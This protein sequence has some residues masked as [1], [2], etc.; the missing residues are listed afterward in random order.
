MSLT[1]ATYAMITG[2]QANVLDFGAD[3]TGVADSTTAIQAAYD[4]LPAAITATAPIGGGTVYFPPGQYKTTA[5]ISI[6]DDNIITKGNGAT[7]QPTHT[8]DVFVIGPDGETRQF[9]VFD[10]IIVKPVATTRDIVRFES[11][12]MQ[13][14]VLNCRFEGA[15]STYTTGY[16]VNFASTIVAF[17]NNNAIT[18]SYFRWL[19]NGIKDGL[20]QVELLIDNCRF[21]NL[22]NQ[23]IVISTG[24]LTNVIACNFES[25]GQTALTDTAIVQFGKTGGP[26]IGRCSIYGCHFEENGST[27]SNRNFDLYIQE[28]RSVLVTANRFYA[29]PTYPTKTAIQCE[30]SDNITVLNNEYQDYVSGAVDIGST[31]ADVVYLGNISVSQPEFTGTGT[32]GL[33]KFAQADGNF[34]VT[35]GSTTTANAMAIKDSAGA[36]VFLAFADGSIG[37]DALANGSSTATF[38]STTKPGATTG[39]SPAGWMPIRQAGVLYWIPVWAN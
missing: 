24:G 35:L 27:A 18:G 36:N 8:G 26:T 21:S 30:N 28:A 7:I 38:T 1:K 3:P 23:A 5:A 4:S 10:S 39:A 6:V 13:C 2:A 19:N 14:K 12:T 15:T 22:A 25:C 31:N 11:G 20:A 37:T 9:V 33:V 16:G 32:Q 17:N 34:N 29:G